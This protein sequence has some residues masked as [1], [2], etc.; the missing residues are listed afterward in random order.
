MRASVMPKTSANTMIEQWLMG[1][2]TLA[3]IDPILSNSADRVLSSRR[4]GQ[5]RSGTKLILS[6]CSTGATLVHRGHCSSMPRVTTVF[7]LRQ[8]RAALE[9]PRTAPLHW[10]STHTIPLPFCSCTCTR[11]A[12]SWYCA[13][14]FTGAPLVM[15]WCCAGVEG[16]PRGLFCWYC[17]DCIG[18]AMAFYGYSMS[19]V[20]DC[21][22][23]GAV[24][25]CWSQHGANVTQHWHCLGP[26]VLSYTPFVSPAGVSG[27]DV[28]QAVAIACRARLDLAFASCQTRTGVASWLELHW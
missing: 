13:V 9:F 8:C 6:W 20:L 18:I 26:V 1:A 21:Y 3:H 27:S 25:R 22:H 19:L 11:W 14:H 10:Y 12:L 23:T 2:N 5:F 17:A 4:P 16:V 15:Y 24:A 7:L 28:A